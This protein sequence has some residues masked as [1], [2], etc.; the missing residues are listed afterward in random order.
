M[1]NF[2][3]FF[4]RFKIFWVFFLFE[5][6]SLIIVF[7]NS[8]FHKASYLNTANSFTGG[9]YGTANNIRKYFHLTVINDSLAAENARLHSEFY[10][11]DTLSHAADTLSVQDTAAKYV[12]RYVYIAADVISNSTSNRNNYLMLNVGSANGVT[13]QCGVVCNEGV[14]GIVYDVSEHFCT[15]ISLLSSNAKISAKIDSSNNAGTLIWNGKSP[16]FAQIDDINKHVKVEPG[17]SI[18]TSGLNYIF[19][20]NVKIGTVYESKVIGTNNTNNISVKL[21]TPFET[22]YKVYVVKNLDIDEQYK[23][24]NGIKEKQ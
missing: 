20:R 23:L 17:Q 8:P 9:I 15:V 16:L 21:S 14:V 3:Y 10:K 5:V 19:P 7:S 6:T 13:K 12:G 18:S 1:Q 2:F 4:I 11:E 24:L 22:L